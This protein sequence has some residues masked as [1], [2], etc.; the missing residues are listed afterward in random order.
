MLEYVF[1]N[2]EPCDRFC[3]FL[4]EQGLNCE[5]QQGDPGMVVRLDEDAVDDALADVIDSRYD[6]LFALDQEIF[7]EGT[8]QTSE[9]YHAAGVVVNL[10]DGRAVYA[11]VPPALLSKIMQSLTPPELGTLV[12]AVVDAVEHPERRTFC[13]R[14]RDSADE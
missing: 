10:A 8:G 13:Q 5:T 3:A 4:K 7:D 9:D 2:T 1:F 6:E 14:M 12:D 11:E